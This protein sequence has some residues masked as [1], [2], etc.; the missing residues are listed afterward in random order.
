M[1][2]HPRTLPS[3]VPRSSPQPG[4]AHTRGPTQPCSPPQPG[5][6]HSSQA[7]PTQGPAHPQPCPAHPR[8]RLSPGA[9]APEM[10]TNRRWIRSW[11]PWNLDRIFSLV[12]K[13]A[14]SSPALSEEPEP[15]A[16]PLHREGDTGC[17]GQQHAMGP[18]S[19]EPN[20]L[21]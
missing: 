15:A 4:P 19:L 8:P 14:A 7:L 16:G 13:G 1:A 18:W 11:L 9:A 10:Q 6:A 21:P 2:G 20:S 17:G 12:A 3:R 5:P